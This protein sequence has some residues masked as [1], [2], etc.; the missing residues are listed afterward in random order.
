MTE[1]KTASDKKHHAHHEAHAAPA[2]YSPEPEATPEEAAPAAV[3][4]APAPKRVPVAA[5]CQAM[6]NRGA[7]GLQFGHA[8]HHSAKDNSHTWSR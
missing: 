3:E 8:G 7:C 1:K 6:S 4:E 5:G 2:A